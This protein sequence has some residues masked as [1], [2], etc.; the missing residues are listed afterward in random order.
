MRKSIVFILLPILM[1]IHSSVAAENP[2]IQDATIEK[3]IKS[4]RGVSSI[5]EAL[6]E[7]GVKQAAALWRS[8]DGSQQDFQQFCRQ[9][10]CKDLNEKTILFNRI[11]DNFEVIYGHNNRISIELM[12]PEQ[13]AGYPSTSVDQLFSAYSGMAHFQEDMY[14][15]KLAFVIIINFPHFTLKEKQHNGHRWSDLEWGFVRLGDVFTSRVPASAEQRIANVST[16]ANSYIDKYNINM[17]QVG[18]YHNQFFWNYSLPLTSHWGLR[19]ELKAAYADR[20]F[21]ADKQEV[22][23]D[24]MKRIIKDEVPVEVIKQ[25]ITYK[26]YPSTNQIMLNGIQILSDAR[27]PK[28]RYQYL[29]DFFKAERAA[30][31]YYTNNFI[32]RKFE[33]EYEISVDDAV[34]LF[35]TL[36]TSPVVEEVAD[37]ISKR[38]GRRLQPFDIWYDGFKNRGSVDQGTLDR[39][40]KA[41]YP[42][43]EAF[44]N[45][46]PNILTKLGFTAEKAKFICDHV[47]VDASLGAGHAIEA[48]MRDDKSTLRTRIGSGG[49]DYKGYNIGV[50]EFGHNVEQTISLHDVANYFL[51]GVPNTA[52]TE[53]LA[54]TFQGKDLELLGI[55]PDS[56]ENTDNLKTLDLFWNCYEIMGV[57]LVDIQVWQWM[58]EHPNADAYEL[59]DAVIGIAKQVWNQYYAPIFKVKDEPILAIYSHA[60]IDP[61]YLSA[62]PI[63]HIIDFQ[64]EN[65]LKGKNMGEE[66]TRIYKLGRLEPNLWMQRAVGEKVSVQTLIHHTEKAARELSGLPKNPNKSQN[67]SKTSSKKKSKK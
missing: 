50:H 30:D 17:Q 5:S 28:S 26:W 36:L 37:L 15:S 54:F 27:N 4:V 53:A 35:T 21:G 65:F 2:F 29:L 34:T 44:E 3:T 13:L 11:C 67:K 19:D 39:M 40:V 8:E 6:V 9:Y 24:V 43:K 45:D 55:P 1:F 61:L 14:A 38:L 63:G 18:S 46:L 16:A 57:S 60:I 7:R 25:D 52:F 62:Y 32:Q 41:K 64:L 47:A 10:F 59:K 56:N 31:E 22:L 66:V 33:E 58:Y 20:T 48:K 49:M 23:Y 42:N 51:A 12:R